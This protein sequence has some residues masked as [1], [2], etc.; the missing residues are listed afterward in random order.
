[1]FSVTKDGLVPQEEHFNKRI[2][3]EDVSRHMLVEQGD[4]AFSGLNFWL[5]SVD[6]SMDPEPF[7]IS[8]DYKVFKIGQDVV[9]SFFRHLARTER[10]RQILRSCAVERASVVRKN[11]D[12][13]SFLN[14]E[15]PLPD[16]SRQEFLLSVLSAA[17]EELIL[18]RRQR[19]ALLKQKRGLM[20]KVLTGEWLVAVPISQ[21]AAE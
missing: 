16:R 14:S 2:S 15:V 20:Q 12:R 7:C 5:G 6:V 21:E 11:F 10:F 19:D 13:G 4:F 17:E 18:L 8:P 9:P 3:N 1:V